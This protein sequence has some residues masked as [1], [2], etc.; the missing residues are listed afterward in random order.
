MII[1]SEVL[2]IKQKYAL[3]TAC[4]PTRLMSRAKVFGETTS[5]EN[6]SWRSE[7]RFWVSVW[8]CFTWSNLHTHMTQFEMFKRFWSQ[9]STNCQ[10]GK[11]IYYVIRWQSVSG[12]LFLYKNR[13]SNNN[14]D[15][16]ITKKYSYCIVIN[17]LYSQVLELRQELHRQRH[18]RQQVVLESPD[19]I[20]KY[21][22]FYVH[23]YIYEKIKEKILKYVHS[24]F[25]QI[26]NKI[27][28][29]K[30]NMK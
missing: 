11:P 17:Y 16:L 6:A 2:F 12:L 30:S 5:P 15:I 20:N 27:E 8:V 1:F 28:V 14:H 10:S 4:V 3:P 29:T 21:L 19:T 13:I 26:V 24:V 9:S 7:T 18:F 22:Y 25:T 23:M